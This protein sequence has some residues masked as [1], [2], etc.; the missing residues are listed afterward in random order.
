MSDFFSSEQYRQDS[1]VEEERSAR[2]VDDYTPSAMEYASEHNVPLDIAFNHILR[3]NGHDADEVKW[4]RIPL[5]ETDTVIGTK[6]KAKIISVVCNSVLTEMYNDTYVVGITG[7]K[8]TFVTYRQLISSQNTHSGDK[9]TPYGGKGLRHVVD[10]HDTG[11]DVKTQTFIVSAPWISS[12]R[13]L[14]T[15]LIETKPILEIRV[16][17]DGELKRYIVPQNFSDGGQ[18]TACA[19]AMITWDGENWTVKILQEFINGF[20]DDVATSISD[21]K[22]YQSRVSQPSVIS[23][24]YDD[25]DVPSVA[26]NYD[27]VLSG[28]FD[29]DCVPS[30]A[31]DDCVPSVAYDDDDVPSV[32]PNYDGVMSGP[33]DD[34]CIPSVAYD[35]V[36]TSDYV[37]EF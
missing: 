34:D 19:S 10:F 13:D 12:R 2:L 30:I 33:F 28:S 35:R 27:G 29:D 6:I 25:D 36:S 21:L 23:V 5:N 37:S 7:E 8:S 4:T 15:K 17:N 14:V 1:Q 26:H 9:N 32:A 11:K 22:N 20:A 3:Y 18:N 16:E 24:A 31:Y